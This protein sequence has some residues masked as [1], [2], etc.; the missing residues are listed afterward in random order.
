MKVCRTL[1]LVA[2]FLGVLAF[3]LG[4]APLG[5]GFTYEGHLSVNGQA[6]SGAYDMRFSLFDS[7]A[8]GVQIGQ[9]VLV[10]SVPV[11]NGFFSVPIDF[12][13]G[14]FTGAMQWL[15]IAVLPSGQ[16]GVFTVLSPRQ[17]LGAVP[18]A[19]YAET[20]GSSAPLAANAISNS[21]LQDG[22]ITR[23][24]LASGQV[25]TALN[26]LHDD[27]T[28]AAGKNVSLTVAGNV[29]TIDATGGGGGG[30]GSGW[31]LGGNAGITP[32]DFLGTI[33]PNPLELK[34][35]NNRVLRLE[36][37]AGLPNVIGG[38]RANFVEPPYGSATIGGGGTPVSSNHVHAYSTT[39]AGGTGNGILQSADSAVVSGGLANSIGQ[40]SQYATIGGGNANAVLANG[41]SAT[42]AGGQA[43]LVGLGAQGAV[44]SGG[45]QNT[46]GGFDSF[47]GGGFDN[48][49]QSGN[50]SGYSV[51][52]G[53]ANNLLYSGAIYATLG[54][55]YSNFVGG[56][57][58]VV[59]GGKGNLAGN[60]LSTVG[61]GLQNTAAA[62]F[63]TV[64]GGRN[65]KLLAERATVSGG[66]SNYS[67]RKL[68]V[69]GGGSQN[70]IGGL[71]GPGSPVGATGDGG[72]IG[73]GTGNLV[74]GDYG[75]VGGGEGN[76]IQP[77]ALHGTV[78]GGD[79]NVS[80]GASSAIGGG[81]S[82]RAPGLGATV[83]GGEKNGAVGEDS[84]VAG[85][86]QN[87]ATN[88][89]ST[90][91]GGGSNVASGNGAAVGGGVSN[92][93]SGP[94][95]AVPG[96]TGNLALGAC[97][98]AAG[99]SAV[100]Q[101]DG[102]FVWS[103]ATLIR[104]GGIVAKSAGLQGIPNGA[105]SDNPNEFTVKATGGVRFFSDP[106]QKVGTMLA[107]YATSWSTISDRN[108]KKNITPIDSR[109]ILEKLDSVPVAKWNY[110]WEEDC[111]TPHLG[112]MAQDFK[113]AFFPGRDDKSITTL[114]FDG[115]E[116]AAIQGLREQLR[117]KT[118][119]W[120]DLKR[121][122]QAL[123]SRLEALEK[124]FSSFAQMRGTEATK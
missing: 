71:A 99:A 66:D 64:A 118:S 57:A 75:F 86:Y 34:V 103:D 95:S 106:L 1:C 51:L 96:G 50:P 87:T 12:G 73:G 54:G 4:S 69:I 77:G 41:A 35:N 63:D 89:F 109:A 56:Y 27:V 80:A 112:P 23:S 8:A 44:I 88:G 29:L 123:N 33:D 67:D 30:A 28:L 84:V 6:A 42:I 46:N 19:I 65:N 21:N 60:Q 18:N 45:M 117:E 94:F 17:V 40:A 2:W 85:G 10:S 62:D 49:I 124:A 47:I 24:K 39:I 79:H 32:A 16:V 90:V 120:R 83:A 93:S 52:V 61:G 72:V 14:I 82:N 58:G 15:E 111:A 26:Q 108:V 9:A 48:T 105:H 122:N 119:E 76:L 115:V 43:N 36:S 22:A 97:A 91:S 107:S 31:Q 53:G 113:A 37:N 114:E 102:S 121:E 3:P 74:Q 7:A 68:S 55:G 70:F 92:S 78:A 101:H 98:L 100:A 5:T 25:V 116:L 110:D 59:G 38:S 11:N 20:S 13:P 81:H 104:L